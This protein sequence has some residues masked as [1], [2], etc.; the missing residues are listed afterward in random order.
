MTTLDQARRDLSARLEA[1]GIDD[2]ALE[3][4]LLVSAAT[5]LEG[6]SLIAEGRREL[7]ADETD[8]LD[9]LSTR[10][11][12]REPLAHIL[13]TQPFWTLDLEVSPDVLI[14]R[15]DTETLV[16]AA[17]DLM[18]PATSMQRIA[19]IGTGSGAIL[20]ALLKERPNAFG[21]G[22]DTSGPALRI[23]ERN[24]ERCG[25][26]GRTSFKP[27][28][29]AEGLP[30]ASFDLAVSNP[31]YIA[32]AVIETLQPEVR[33]HD[34]RGA[35]DGGQDGL[36]AYRALMPQ[37]W[38]ILKPGGAMAVEIGYDQADAVSVLA[39]DAGFQHIGVRRD[40]GGNDR[41]IF[42]RKAE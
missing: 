12:A 13:G 39:T 20:L 23:A 38:R 26:D 31:P 32:S 1:A 8:R 29:W 17:L 5:G 10:R 25:L 16:E 18:P 28:S 2:A 22:T 36:D 14:P 19:D 35:L 6:A 34:P 11:L 40:L 30:G 24:A 4:K 41:V 33:D 3:A 21:V 42:G 37:L 27:V 7:S 9:T 15:A